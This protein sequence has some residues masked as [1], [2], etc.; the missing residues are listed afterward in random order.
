MQAIPLL[1]GLTENEFTMIKDINL[2]NY[3]KL[4]FMN[5]GNNVLLIG[6]KYGY[7][8]NIN[9]PVI[10]PLYKA[11]KRKILKTS[12]VFPISDK[13]RLRFEDEAIL[14]LIR[15]GYLKYE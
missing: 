11:Y 13:E 1:S 8:L 5:A 9:H 2:I 12:E 14:Y 3:N 7:R 15:K 4:C 6:N 10:N